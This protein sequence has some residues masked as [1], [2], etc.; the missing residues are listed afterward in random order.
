M[1][2]P[3]QSEQTAL[4]DSERRFGTAADD[5]TATYER[6]VNQHGVAVRRLIL[7]GPEEVDA[8]ALSRAGA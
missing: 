7:V 1:T 3:E 6:Y 8:A 5:F 4:V 2:F